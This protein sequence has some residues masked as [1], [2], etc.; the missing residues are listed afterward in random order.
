MLE[1]ENYKY[2]KKVDVRKQ[3]VA[4]GGG[5]ENIQR[6][7]SDTYVKHNQKFNVVG[8]H[9]YLRCERNRNQ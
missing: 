3:E 7:R 6:E 2:D 5:F 8:E 4:W 1:S 9:Q